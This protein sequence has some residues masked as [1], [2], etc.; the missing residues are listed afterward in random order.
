MRVSRPGRCG[1]RDRS[2]PAAVADR[3][4]PGRSVLFVDHP[5]GGRQDAGGGH[6]YARLAR[7]DLDAHRNVVT[8]AEPRPW[9]DKT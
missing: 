1:R 4:P 8:N 9:F 5:A 7:I 3:P 2:P 6:H